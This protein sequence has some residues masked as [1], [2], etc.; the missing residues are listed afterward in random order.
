MAALVV[1]ARM[2]TRPCLGPITT[3]HTRP[4][5]NLHLW[6]LSVLDQ[7]LSESES[8]HR[9]ARSIIGSGR[10]GAR[11]SDAGALGPVTIHRVRSSLN[12]WRAGFLTVGIKRWSLNVGDT[13]PPSGDRMLDWWVWSS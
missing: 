2:R 9:E 11:G 10:A 1:G 12:Y 4:I 8:S 3:E 13:W 6:S 5:V 7:T